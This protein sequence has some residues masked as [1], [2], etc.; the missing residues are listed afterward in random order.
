METLRTFLSHDHK[1]CDGLFVAAEESAANKDW[2]AAAARFDAFLQGMERHLTAEE[3]L[4][5]PAYEAQVGGPTGPTNV[6]RMEH[7]QMR[8]LF[9]EM[10]Q[11]VAGRDADAFLGASETLLVMMQQHNLKE[12]QILYPMIDM[13]MG[14]ER[15]PLLARVRSAIGG[16]A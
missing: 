8:E 6:M 11:A 14:P 12:E 16:E 5:F 13:T 2:S 4:L 1:H 10:A 7:G 9:Q 15:D 3:E